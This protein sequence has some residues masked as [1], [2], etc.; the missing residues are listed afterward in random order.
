MPARYQLH[1]GR[2]RSWQ[3]DPT[4]EQFLHEESDDARWL[5][6]IAQ[7]MQEEVDWWIVFDL[8]E[9]MSHHSGWSTGRTTPHLMEADHAYTVLRHT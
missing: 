3:V 2:G 5:R 1:C 4:D 7:A 9:G 8:D 6:R